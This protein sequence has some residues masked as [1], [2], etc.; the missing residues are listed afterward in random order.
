MDSPSPSPP[1]EGRNP[2]IA[3]SDELIVGVREN[4]IEAALYGVQIATVHQVISLL[5]ETGVGFIP[6]D[7]DIIGWSLVRCIRGECDVSLQLTKDDQCK[8]VYFTLNTDNKY[9]IRWQDYQEIRS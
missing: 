6:T 7:I 8:T 3:R 9:I 2:Y 1:L 5:S 4:H